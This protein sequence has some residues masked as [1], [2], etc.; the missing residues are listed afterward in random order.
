V[1]HTCTNCK[2]CAGTKPAEKRILIAGFGGQGALFTGRVLANMGMLHGLNVSWMPS[3][4]AEMR[5]G[6]TN[7]GVILSESE[8]GSPTVPVMDVLEAMN[9]PSLIKFEHKV[10]PGGV[11][12]YDSSIIDKAHERDDVTY[13]PIPAT[14]LAFDNGVPGLGNLIMMGK[15][16]AVM[17]FLPRELVPAAMQ[18]S[19]PARRKDMYDAN[20]KAIDLG[21]AL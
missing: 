20:L 6:T 4:G 5:G 17:G 19:V 18:S 3:Y 13:Y 1:G 14:Q 16:L 8:I 10:V 2:G 11:I 12:L 15:M 7:C 9:I 21:Y